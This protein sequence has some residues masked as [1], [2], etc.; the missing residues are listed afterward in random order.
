[1]RNIFSQTLR[2]PL[3][4]RP[5]LPADLLHLRFPKFFST[6]K[7]L[8]LGTFLAEPWNNV[9]MY[10][11]VV[12]R[13]RFAVRLSYIDPDRAFDLTHRF[14]HLSYSRKQETNLIRRH[15]V[16]RSIVFLGNEKC[17]ALIQRVNV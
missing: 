14:H 11:N 7:S 15:L 4:F 17:V 3:N 1:M 13:C 8:A 10:M 12:L 16:Q 5:D 9:D 6:R 2:S